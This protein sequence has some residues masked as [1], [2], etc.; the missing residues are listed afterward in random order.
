MK[1]IGMALL[2][3]AMGCANFKAATGASAS[4]NAA[5]KAL[6]AA[7]WYICRG[8]SVGAVERRFGKTPGPYKAI[9]TGSN[10]GVIGK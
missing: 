3:L 1:Y 8:A 7:H 5:D 2:L 4:A 6:Q 9:C 10:M